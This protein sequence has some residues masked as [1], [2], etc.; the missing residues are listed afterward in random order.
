VR[1]LSG[2]AVALVLLFAP[3]AG[4]AQAKLP[5]GQADGVRVVRERGAI[6]FVF[7]HRAAKLYKRIAGKF[8]SVD[9]PEERVDDLRAGTGGDRVIGVGGGGGVTMRAPRRGRRLATGDRTR[10]MDY[11]RVW[12]RARTVR[13]HGKRE[14]IGA[15]LIVSVPLT[16]TGAVF[17]DEQAKAHRLARVLIAAAL[18]AEQRHLIGWATYELLRDW[19]FR[20]AGKG[21][22]GLAGPSDTPPAG[23]IGYYSD[24][25]DHVVVV[26]LSASGRR[27]FIEYAGDVVSTNVTEYIYAFRPR[28]TP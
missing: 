27:L 12:L 15:R 26:I 5:V 1:I 21:F 23:A 4:V 16:Q 9:C 3:S 10:G 11:C 13:R 20:K 25:D 2:I 18:V 22:V 24:G 6:V 17:L 8:V 7:T 19:G 14:R 28:V